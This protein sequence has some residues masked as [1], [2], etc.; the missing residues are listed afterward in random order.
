MEIIRTASI[1]FKILERRGEDY[2]EA[3]R[4]PVFEGI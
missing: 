1:N 2:R 4:D 3:A